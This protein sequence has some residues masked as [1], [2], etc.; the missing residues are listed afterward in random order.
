MHKAQCRR[1]HSSLMR[2][3]VVRRA[4]QANSAMAHKR[5]AGALGSALASRLSGG[6]AR[7]L[8]CAQRRRRPLYEPEPSVADRATSGRGRRALRSAMN[9]AAALSTCH[10]LQRQVRGSHAFSRCRLGPACACSRG[11]SRR[12]AGR[13]RQAARASEHAAAGRAQR[14]SR[15][16]SRP[17]SHAGAR[18]CLGCRDA[19]VRTL[20]ACTRLR[21]PCSP[22]SHQCR[23]SEHP[24][25]A[26]TVRSV[27]RRGRGERAPARLQPRTHPHLTSGRRRATG[28]AGL[29]RC[30]YD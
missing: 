7:G 10:R 9:V 24:L 30:T 19:M 13:G 2:A 15:H 29:A 18:A 12:R 8:G 14:S 21:V 16:R 23:H 11:V 5:C 17:R 28:A 26:Q 3:S 20:R 25:R 27:A 6:H 1:C 22:G 4:L